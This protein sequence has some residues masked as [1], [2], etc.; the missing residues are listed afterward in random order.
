M[1]YLLRVDLLRK[2]S[3]VS[4]SNKTVKIAFI[5]FCKVSQT[6]EILSLFLFLAKHLNLISPPWN[7][8]PGTNESFIWEK[9]PGDFWQQN[10]VNN[11]PQIEKVSI[12]S[13]SLTAGPWILVQRNT[14][15]LDFLG[16]RYLMKY[17]DREIDF[18]VKKEV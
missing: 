6:R 10:G 14:I 7:T 12:A 13:H 9:F 3:R 4:R 16:I 11:L 5:H 1:C 15:E 18:L 17:R 8:Q 2:Q